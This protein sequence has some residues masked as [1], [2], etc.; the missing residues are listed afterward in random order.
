MKRYDSYI[1]SV[2][3]ENTRLKQELAELEEMEQSQQQPIGMD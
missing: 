1:K 2:Q 3:E